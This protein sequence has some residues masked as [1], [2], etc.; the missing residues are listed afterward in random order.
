MTVGALALATNA[1]FCTLIVEK[2]EI[3]PND[4]DVI[5]SNFSRFLWSPPTLLHWKA[6][7]KRR[8]NLPENRKMTTSSA[9][10]DLVADYKS[11]SQYHFSAPI[12][13][14][15]YSQQVVTALDHY[16]N[17]DY[18]ITAWQ[19]FV[20]LVCLCVRCFAVCHRQRLDVSRPASAG[21]PPFMAD[22]KSPDLK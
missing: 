9:R 1:V 4:F 15:P 21:P 13:R 5:S 14:P 8:R 16:P 6:V 19:R 7:N 17:V 10:S 2:C 20:E 12:P 18:T 3:P 11:A 22:T